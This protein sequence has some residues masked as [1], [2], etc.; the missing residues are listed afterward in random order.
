MSV[1]KVVSRNVLFLMLGD[2]VHKIASILF[3]TLV[4][5][6]IGAESFGVFSIA[7]VLAGLVAVV[8]DPGVSQ[9][10]Y[11]NLSENKEPSPFLV[12]A[13]VSL[14]LLLLPL[15]LLCLVALAFVFKYPPNVFRVIAVVG[16]GVLVLQVRQIYFSAF[17]AVSRSQ[18]VAVGMWIESL[19]LIGSAAAI[20]KRNLDLPQIA[21]L[22]L[23]ICLL[24]AVF[25]GLLYY[26][27]I[28]VRY[29]LSSP[30]YMWGV[31]RQALPLGLQGFMIL[32][33]LYADSVMLSLMFSSEV[34]GY[35]RAA[36]AL[37]TALNI[38]GTALSSSVFPFFVRLQ[39]ND[40]NRLDEAYHKT[41]KY[42]LALGCGIAMGTTLLANK[43][44]LFFY[45]SGFSTSILPL[46]VL[47]W[48]EALIFLSFA[49]NAV[50]LA[51]NRRW[52]LVQGTALA[53][54]L[55]VALNMLIIRF[56]GAVGAASTTVA[57]EVFALCFLLWQ[58][59][60]SGICFD[61]RWLSDLGRVGL[62]CALMGL[63]LLLGA[64]L[65]LILLVV[66]GAVVYGYVLLFVGFLDG[67]DIDLAKQV[68]TWT[69]RQPRVDS[70]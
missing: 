58:A 18:L 4:A 14:V 22:Y 62:A 38:I 69:E 39:A 40:R 52:A 57:T 48:S 31:L 12:G 25:A 54:I 37:V 47:I 43:I 30:A 45:G 70:H 55:N 61:R 2:V 26:I 59:R 27:R 1:S 9:I 60:R 5:R 67:T 21:W 50:L 35:Y 29:R 33:Y 16:L 56:Y 17:K 10:L 32:I 42:L 24:S 15:S 34:I 23:L 46:Q 64:N 8:A 44:I 28:G 49:T 13:G 7:L 63:V 11:R 6:Q 65:P 53:A 36:Y 68:F 41:M 3:S 20:V 19:L 66:L 51:Q